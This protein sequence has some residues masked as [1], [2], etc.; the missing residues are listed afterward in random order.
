MWRNRSWIAGIAIAMTLVPFP[1]RGSTD[2]SSRGVSVEHDI[3]GSSETESRDSRPVANPVADSAYFHQQYPGSLDGLAGNRLAACPPP[4]LF[5]RVR[6]VTE[7]GLPDSRVCFNPGATP[8]APE[9]FQT[10]IDPVTVAALTPWPETSVELNPHVFSLVN[11][12]TWAW[13]QPPENPQPG[14][15]ADG[16]SVTASVTVPDLAN[17]GTPVTVRVDAQL[18]RWCYRFEDRRDDRPAFVADAVECRHGKGNR[19]AEKVGEDHGRRH[20]AEHVYREPGRYTVT[21]EQRWSGVATETGP[22]PQT[23]ALGP[24]T[25][26]FQRTYE[27]RELYG[28]LIG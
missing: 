21:V 13:H 14:Q 27:V 5:A 19:S 18:D 10:V 26:S 11:L 17:G 8:D 6:F 25:R 22:S 20:A 9:V 3:G 2:L 12:E 16:L 7:T 23:W 15:G 1:A 28:R 24:I 4:F